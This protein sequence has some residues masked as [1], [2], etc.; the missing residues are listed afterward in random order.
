[1][2]TCLF[3]LLALLA[4]CFSCLRDPSPLLGS[5]QAVDVRENGDSLKLNPAEIGFEFLPDNRYRYRSTLN[6][7]EAGTWQYQDGYLYAQDTT[8]KGATQYV[9]AVDLL[10]PDSLL[11]RMKA[12]SAERIVLLL[13]Q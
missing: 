6:Y 7:R 4:V 9:V 10:R 1:M 13:R 12:D 3:T 8:G 2:R 5:W 11:L